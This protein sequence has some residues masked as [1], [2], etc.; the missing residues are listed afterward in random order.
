[1]SKKI[2]QKLMGAGLMMISAF[3]VVASGGD[4]S[5]ACMLAPLGAWMVGSKRRVIL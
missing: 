3:T 1:M 5:A 2:E 4:A